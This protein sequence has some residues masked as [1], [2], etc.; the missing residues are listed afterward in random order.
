MDPGA[1]MG[2]FE[3]MMQKMQNMSNGERKQMMDKNRALCLCSGCPT[4]FDCM[5]ETMEALFCLTDKSTC[6][7]TKKACI[8][9]TCPVTPLMGLSHGYD[10]ASGSE[11]EVQKTSF[12]RVSFFMIGSA[13]DTN[14][15]FYP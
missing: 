13:S 12:S 7:I 5:R 9:P 14:T 6:T 11:K 10:C 8:C 2:K 1:F 15:F 3:G 4:Y